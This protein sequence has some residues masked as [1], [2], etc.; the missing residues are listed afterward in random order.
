MISREF[1]VLKLRASEDAPAAARQL[2]AEGWAMVPGV[3]GPDEAATLKAEIDHVFDATEPSRDRA[4]TETDEFRYAILND[5]PLCQKAVG[6]PRILEVIEPLLGEDCHVIANTA[7]RN[8]EGHQGGPWHIDAG[9]HIP[10]PEGVPWPDEIPY[11]VFVIGMHLYLE[12]CPMEAGPTAVVP[13]S[14]RSGRWPEGGFQ[15][16]RDPDYDGRPPVYLTAKAG[17]AGFF[18]SDA[19]HRGTPAEPGYRR[20]FLQ[21]H[22]GRRDIAQ[23][24]IPTDQVNSL[25]EAAKARA[26]TERERTLAGLHKPF[27]YDG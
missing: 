23:R 3:L 27:F 6:H 26:E 17:D 1:G 21:A 25:T 24:L 5:S 10:R 20:H 4:R 11:P 8:H 7:W 2:E 22:Y 12:D 19:W 16:E 13:G 18:V 9:P 15:G 14:H